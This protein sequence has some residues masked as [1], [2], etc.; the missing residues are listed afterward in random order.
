MA[1]A[2]LF[3]G[4]PADPAVVQH[5]R[6]N[7]AA[8]GVDDHRA[9]EILADPAT[10][11]VGLRGLQPFARVRLDPQRPDLVARLDDGSF[12]AVVASSDP[13]LDDSLDR[14]QAQQSV[15]HYVVLA[16][17]R[18]PPEHVQQ[19]AEQAGVG[20]VVAVERNPVVPASRGLAPDAY[21][22]QNALEEV[23]AAAVAQQFHYNV[24]THFV[25]WT[26]AVDPYRGASVKD[27]R[28]ALGSYPMPSGWT[29]ALRGA[30][31]LHLVTRQ[32]DH[33]SLTEVGRE[34]RR[35]TPPLGDWACLHAGVKAT[36][37]RLADLQPDAAAAAR[38]A[39]A[40][41]P[42]AR[43]VSDALAGVGGRATTRDLVAHCTRLNPVLGPALFLRSGGI[44]ALSQPD[45]TV[46]AA[47]AAGDHVKDRVATQFKSL[48][49][50]FGVLA[51]GRVKAVRNGQLDLDR[52]IWEIDSPL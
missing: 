21:V 2:P 27:A 30:I 24:P 48:L 20:I 5:A 18:P 17:G 8:H 14:A 43:F 9:V 3:A 11:L 41:L 6:R 22:L 32:G 39:L 16:L 34:V 49:T 10:H 45:G 13:S 36:G 52:S 4:A 25:A 47:R 29:A 40:T 38:C 44:A 12:A 28:A 26:L 19:R 23:Q 1:D 7:L 51:P 37:P 42:A 46:D 33:L 15:A 35:A 31:L 50:H